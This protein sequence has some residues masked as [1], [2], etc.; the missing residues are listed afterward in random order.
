MLPSPSGERR[1]SRAEHLSRERQFELLT[2]HLPIMVANCDQDVRFKYVNKAYADRLGLTPEQIIGCLASDVIGADAARV[3]MPHV[4]RALAGERVEY[5][6]WIPYASLGRRYMRCIYSPERDADG[7]VIGYVAGIIDETARKNAE[8][9]LALSRARFDFVATS[10]D[11]GVWSCDVPL[12]DLIWNNACKAHFGLAPDAIVTI[13]T[14]FD[15]IH[16]DDVDATRRAIDDALN[17][18]VPCD[19]EYRARQQDGS[20]RWIRAVGRTEYDDQGIARR[21]EGVTVDITA[22]KR[23]EAALA[24]SRDRLRAALDASGTGTFRWDI[25]S[26]NLDW[27]GNLD[28]LFGLQPGA[29][30]RSLPDFLRF[31]HPDDRQ[32]VVDACARCATIN[33]DFDE[34]FRVVWPDGTV[35]WLF[36]KGRVFVA[37][38]GTR[39]MSGACVDI[40]DRRNKED[41]LR[42]ADRQKDEFL[43]MLAHEIRNP[44]APM[45]YSASILER[46]IQDPTLKRPLEVIT[47][48][49][50]RMIRIVDDLLDVSRVTQGKISLQRSRVC[51]GTLLR[52]CV[53]ATQAL[54]AARRHTVTVRALDPTLVVIG[55]EVRLAQIIENLLI[56]A[57]KYTPDGGRIE[58]SG[59]PAGGMV[60]IAV[61]DTG[62][63]IAPEMLER[64]FDL[65]AQAD[66]SLDRAEG[67]LGIGLTLV[68]RLTRMHGGHASVSSAG[69]GLGSTFTVT[70]PRAASDILPASGDDQPAMAVGRRV[71]VVD[72]NVDSAEMLSTLLEMRGHTVCLAH[73]GPSA[74]NAAQRFQP[75]IVLLDI[76]LPG[77]D[78][79]QVIRELRALPRLERATIV[80]TTGYGR[81]EDRERCLAAGFDDHVIKPLDLDEIERIVSR[82]AAG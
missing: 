77:R 2:S 34:E 39:Y 52:Q 35:R 56:N 65:F 63:G 41:A 33:A 32:R 59:E 49:A 5:E 13:D 14:F 28:R 50:T 55:D 53:E 15:R 71:L 36:D 69:L 40:T 81:D 11:I 64:V 18:G 31:V 80:A 60:S 21:F 12:G 24:D 44:L 38:D 4:Q 54:F 43:G 23:A 3:I 20:F 37:A 8:D 27:D 51:V 46:R 16:P 6:A 78:G 72:D 45:M 79:F 73:D 9:A 66:T 57:A 1:P 68:D 22:T 42:A 30:V 75:H 76:G 26:N 47:R 61:T 19:I 58:L 67:G 17:Q 7:R 29:T 70:L 25:D 10:A 82:T 48:Q 62:I 74:A